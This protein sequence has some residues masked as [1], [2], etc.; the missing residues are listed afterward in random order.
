MDGQVS[1][2]D[3]GCAQWVIRIRGSNA[4]IFPFLVL[5]PVLAFI[6]PIGLSPLPLCRRFF[7]LRGWV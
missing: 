4:F 1:V 7:I 6:L 2:L 5:L 3:L